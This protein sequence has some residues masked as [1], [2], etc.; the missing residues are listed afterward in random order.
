MKSISK[1]KWVAAIIIGS[2]SLLF[3]F[4]LYYLV[5][6]YG[7]IKVETKQTILSCIQ[8]ADLE[9][10]YSRLKTEKKNQK[11]IDNKVTYVQGL[12]LEGS[13]TVKSIV[14]KDKSILYSTDKN[15]KQKIIKK[16][17]INKN[18]D[19]F[20]KIFEELRMGIHVGL[21]SIYPINIALYDSIVNVELKGKGLMTQTLYSEIINNKTGKVIS[22]SLPLDSV[23]LIK[24][25]V[26]YTYVFNE[27]GGRA[28]RVYLPLLTTLILRQMWG[29]LLST[30]LIVFILGFAFCYFI[31]TVMRQK[32]LEEMKDDF[33]NNMTHELKTPISVTYSAID[34]LLHFKQ[35]DNKEKRNS[36]LQIC[37]DQLTQLSSLVE[38]I[39]SMSAERRKTLILNKEKISMKTLLDQL[40]TLYQMKSDR[41]IN[42][43]L[44][45]VP[46]N[47]TMNADPIHWKNIISNLIDNALKYSEEEVP[48]I[49][50]Q[51]SQREHEAVFVIRD[52]GIGIALENQKHI[53]EKFYRVPHGNVQNVKGYGLGLFYVKT[54]VEKHGGSIVVKS[55][56]NEG[57]RFMIILPQ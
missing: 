11:H 16:T 44:Q 31:R 33:T 45:V 42:F 47:L 56:L 12:D 8:K 29:I 21:D 6:L 48:A 4:N 30:A 43:Q 34:T 27:Q 7:S 2:I 17:S 19:Y 35:G 39:L 1:F 10:I 18:G 55:A 50:I 38:Q 22:S 32:S 28:Y 26:P 25:K 14:T 57:T 23:R 40:I 9:E 52:H 24:T 36:Y 20:T 5:G 49:E 13:D 15:G 37:I 3:L 51:C 41:K 53:F 46:S 54:M